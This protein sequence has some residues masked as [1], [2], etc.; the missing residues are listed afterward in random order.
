MLFILAID[1]LKRIL[2]LATQ[3][4]ILS[5]LNNRVAKMRTSLYADDVTIIVNPIK[6][7]IEA[8]ERIL[9]TFIQASSLVTNF[10]KS[11]VHSIRCE[12]VDLNSPWILPRGAQ[13]LPMPLP[14]A[15]APHP[16]AQKNPHQPVIENIRHDCRVGKGDSPP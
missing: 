6:E 16:Q 9:V 10:E 7:E 3:E 8:V 4:N 12:S 11:T 14:G 13:E 5:P 2:E 1:P 15:A